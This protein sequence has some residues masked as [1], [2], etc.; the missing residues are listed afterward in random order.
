MQA[1]LSDLSKCA[2]TRWNGNLLISAIQTMMNFDCQYLSNYMKWNWLGDCGTIASTSN[3][4]Y[5]RSS[6]T[7]A[8]GMGGMSLDNEISPIT[9]N[10]FWWVNE[11]QPMK[12][13]KMLEWTDFNEIELTTWKS[14]LMKKCDGNEWDESQWVN[15][16]KTSRRIWYMKLT[17]TVP[18]GLLWY[19]NHNQNSTG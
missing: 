18:T 16:V 6:S 11:S 10:S 17:P 1:L 13:L 12:T 14:T 4:D 15:F 7:N 8:Y 19:H 9:W 5:E 2:P 3:S